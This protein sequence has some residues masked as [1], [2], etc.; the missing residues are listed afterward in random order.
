M[1]ELADLLGPLWV[2]VLG[3]GVLPAENTLGIGKV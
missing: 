3:A 1:S 2:E